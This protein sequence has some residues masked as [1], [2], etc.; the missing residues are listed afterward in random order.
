MECILLAG[1][2]G[3]RLRSVVS[4]LPKCL[5]P[6][7]GK[8]F[9]SYIL[10][11]LE[12]SGFSKIILSLGY[13][14]EAVE[15][16]LK[17]YKGSAEI[18]T[19][20]EPEPLGTGGAV[21]FAIENAPLS[22]ECSEVAVLNAD[23]FL[24]IDFK[25]MLKQHKDNNALITIALKQMS[26]FN[27]YGEVVLDQVSNKILKFKEKHFCK[28]GLINGGVYILSRTLLDNYSEKFSMETDVFER[29]QSGVYGYVTDGYFIDIGIPEDY[30]TAQSDFAEGKYKPFDT[31][32]LDRDGV[33]NVLRPGDYVKK[34]DEF[35][36]IPN[37]TESLRQLSP[38]FRRIIVISNQR[39]VGKKLM[40]ETDLLEINN[41]MLCELKK[42]G[43][44]I[45]RIYTCT[46]LEENDPD[47]KPNIG[48][49]LKAKKEFPDLD[50]SNSLM[51]GDSE[52]DIVFAEKAGIPAI[53]IGKDEKYGNLFTFA[54]AMLKLN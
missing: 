16:W 46:A 48:M 38:L 44:T 42:G 27:R 13:R 53:K 18:I 1:G 17:E 9:L 37:V 11:S 30:G 24:G 7:A 31:L 23:T 8:P 28:K 22:E 12:S 19:V 6:V 20:V 49:A 40:T 4:D 34:I 43:V 54:S 39:G 47:R 45:D 15:E 41:Y 51:I 29:I 35:D 52:S 14:H 32:F 2:Q 26:D 21:K 33:I 50:F 5:A 36:F 3:T 10:E 25:K